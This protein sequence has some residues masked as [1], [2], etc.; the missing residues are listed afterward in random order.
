MDFLSKHLRKS[1]NDHQNKRK[2]SHGTMFTASDAGLCIAKSFHRLNG[3]KQK[4]PE[5]K[6]L[7]MMKL[8]DSLHEI[9]Q[10][11]AHNEDPQNTLIEF[12]MKNEELKVC[13]SL[14]L[15]LKKE[16]HLMDIKTV[17]TYKF[18]RMFGRNKETKPAEHHEMQLGTYGMMLEEAGYPVEKISIMYINRNDGR[19][20]EKD[21]SLDFIEY[22]QGYWAT[23]NMEME[24]GP[25]DYNDHFM[26]PMYDWECN[27]CS[28]A[29]NCEWKLEH[30]VLKK[31]RTNAKK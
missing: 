31:G 27:Y 13:G 9:I 29:D 2:E 1:A 7:L 10:D 18:S 14:D 12:F 20:Q 11:A 17:H 4:L 15:Y 8:G 24:Y 25:D 26:L 28:F 6:A 22:A 5:D 16:K 3:T 19:I 23:V 30:V 21:V